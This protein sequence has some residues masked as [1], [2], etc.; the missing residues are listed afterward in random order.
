MLEAGTLHRWAAAQPGATRLAGRGT[1]WRVPLPDVEWVV[2]HYRRGGAVARMLGDRYLRRGESRPLRELRASAEVLRRGVA[3]PPVLAAA[4]Y[5]GVVFRRGDLVTAFI[6]GS[7]DLA[8]VTFARPRRPEEE[9]VAAWAAA[10]SLVRQAA[11]EGVLHPDLNLKNI[12]I[13]PRPGGISAWL[14]DLDRCRIRL[15]AV[16]SDLRRMADRLD[17]SRRKIE[18]ATGMKVSRAELDAF[19]EALHA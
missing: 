10:G 19:R 12:L 11:T 7:E 16:P 5:A 18:A 13:A 8:H 3:T 6:A 4:I 9:R 17:R 14:I 15:H 2:R 1:V